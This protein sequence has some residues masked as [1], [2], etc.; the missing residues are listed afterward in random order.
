MRRAAQFISHAWRKRDFHSLVLLAIIGVIA[1]W[2]IVLPL[3][4]T[5]QHATINR[6]HLTTGSFAVWSLQQPIPPMYNLENQYWYSPRKLT[7]GELTDPPPPGVKT[8]YV[9]HFPARMITCAS[10]RLMML[11]NQRDCWF[12]LKSGYQASERITT[13]RLDSARGS[14]ALRLRRVEENLEF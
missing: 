2:L 11:D 10:G 5:V 12:Y 4:P 9:N 3:S 7:R 14:N 8:G 1:V 6:F 13:Y